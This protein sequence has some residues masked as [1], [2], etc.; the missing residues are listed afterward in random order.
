MLH[1][2]L[3]RLEVPLREEVWWGGWWCGGGILVETRVGRR[4]EMWTTQRVDR[5]GNKIWSVK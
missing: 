2:T 5:H 3:K 4:Y 1:L